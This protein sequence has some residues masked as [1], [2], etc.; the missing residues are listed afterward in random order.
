MIGHSVLLFIVSLDPSPPPISLSS[1]ASCPDLRTHPLGH[2]SLL[3][4]IFHMCFDGPSSTH[5]CPQIDIALPRC[6]HINQL[7]IYRPLYKSHVHEY[8]YLQSCHT[9]TFKC[10]HIYSYHT[11]LQRTMIILALAEKSVGAGV[12]GVP[13]SVSFA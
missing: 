4:H 8:V 12:R 7:A 2:S 11:H 10:I 13:T 1:D 6:L 5:N 3:I 9:G